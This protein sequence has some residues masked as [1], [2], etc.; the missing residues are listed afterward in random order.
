MALDFSPLQNINPGEAFLQGRQEAQR[1]A[2]AKTQLEQSQLQLQLTRDQLDQARRDRAALDAMAKS[3]AENG[4]TGSLDENFDKMIASGIPQYVQIGISG[5][6]KLVEQ[7]RFEQIMGGAAPGAAPAMPTGAPVMTPT[8]PAGSPVGAALRADL[9]GAAPTNALAP[10]PAAPAPVT[11]ALAGPVSQINSM[12]SKRDQLI[13]LGTPQAMKAAEVLDREIVALQRQHVVGGA[14]VGPGGEVIYREPEKPQATPPDIATMQ[15]LGYPLT[16]AGYAQFREAQRQERLLSPEEEAQRI[17]IARESRP[18]PQPREPREPSAP[19]AVVD[20]ATGKIKYVPRE[21]AIGKTPASALE[22]LAPKE[23][24]K[25]EAAFP[26]A[27][28]AIKGVEAN[29]DTFVKDLRALRNHPGLDGI[30]G[31]VFGRTASAKGSSREAQALYDKIVA[32]G[33]FQMLQ[34][35]REAS[36]TGGALGNVSNEEGRRLQAA[37][38]AIDR[39]QDA[40][41]VRRAIDG[42]IAEIEG[43]KA[44]TREA[45]E[46]TYEYKQRGGAAP[47][48]P[49]SGV[50][51]SNPL[52][53]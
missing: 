45:Y 5:K 36:K 53:K 9:G 47:A 3:F 28:L 1:N 31:M 24:Q 25:R 8:A 13:S 39:V 27:T 37:F 52:L 10:T 42:A 11:N 46:S 2:L 43:A 19:I 14:L 23:I 50:D 21:E 40:D 38:A 32:K 41:S 6:Q 44:R 48:A 15:A 7:R 22:G 30:T 4:H 16:T 17:R 35:M 33:G 49:K 18:L 29:A 34:A 20:D 12:R 26:Q 51:A